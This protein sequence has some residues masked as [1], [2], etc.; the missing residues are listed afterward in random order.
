[1]TGAFSGIGEHFARRLEEGG[2]DLVLILPPRPYG[3]VAAGNPTRA[4]TA[5]RPKR[6]F[7]QPSRYS[8]SPA[9]SRASARSANARIATI[10]CSR[11]VNT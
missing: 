1:M 7:S 2:Y 8:D 5:F 6:R 9:A 3:A 11:S 10:L 4:L